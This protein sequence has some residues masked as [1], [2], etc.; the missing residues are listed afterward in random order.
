VPFSAYG[1]AGFPPQSSICAAQQGDEEAVRAGA[2]RRH[3]D[4]ALLVDMALR[5]LSLPGRLLETWG[6]AEH[7]HGG[8]AEL[9][10]S[11]VDLGALV[12]ECVTD[13]RSLLIPLNAI[14]YS[15]DWPATHFCY[16]IRTWPKELA[17]SLPS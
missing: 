13:I 12:H 8:A 4:A 7:L 16:V 15:T 3:D 10:W 14:I 5:S 17:T 1:K 11:R 6:R 9:T 2:R